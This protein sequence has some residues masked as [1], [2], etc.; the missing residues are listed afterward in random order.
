MYGADWNRTQGLVATKR[1]PIVLFAHK[2]DQTRSSHQA[3]SA[4][5]PPACFAQGWRYPPFGVAFA[6]FLNN[7]W[8]EDREDRDG[9]Q[10]ILE[11]IWDE[12][13]TSADGGRTENEVEDIL[14]HAF[15]KDRKPWV[16]RDES[17]TPVDPPYVKP[18]FVWS[19]LKEW[20]Q[21]GPI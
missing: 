5:Q 3:E 12:C 11:T 4:P 17:G 20:K 1:Q 21:E 2:S 19:S 13:G 7:S 14:D 6:N 18:A 8:E 9:I 15:A 10:G 16:I